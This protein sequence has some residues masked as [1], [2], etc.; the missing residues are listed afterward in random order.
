MSW[1]NMTESKALTTPVT[2]HWTG[3]VANVVA[4]AAADAG[5]GAPRTLVYAG[6]SS[7]TA[8]APPRDSDP[9]RELSWGP[10]NIYYCEPLNFM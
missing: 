5:A 1:T 9:R 3:I 7:P 8:R 10:R 2:P 4:L 6:A